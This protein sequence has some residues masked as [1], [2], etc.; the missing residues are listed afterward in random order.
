M[1]YTKHFNT[2]K[3]SQNQPIPG[4]NQVLNNAGGFVYET[5][6]WIRLDR[7][8]I[9][10]T[11]GGTYYA[12]EKKLTVENA[13]CILNLLKKDGQRVVN[14]VVQ[15]SKEGRASKNDPAIFVLAMAAKMGDDATRAVA[16]EAIP[17]VCRIG[18][19]IFQFAEAVKAFGGWGRGTRN[20]IARWY[21][22]MPID[23]LSYQVI[24]YQQRNGWSHRDLLRLSHAKTKDQDRNAIY[25]WVTKGLPKGKS[26][27]SLDGSIIQGF[28][29]VKVASSSIEVA[30]LIR[31]FNLPREV[32]PTEFLNYSSV[33]EA[34]LEKMP[35]MAMIRNLATM[36]RVGLLAPMNIATDVVLER[37]SDKELLRKARIHP[38]QV[39]AALKTYANGCGARG[40]NSWDPVQSIVDALDSAFYASF[41]YIKPSGKKTFLAVDCSASMKWGQICGVPGLTPMIGAAALAMVQARV[42]KKHFIAYFSSGSSRSEGIG[43]LKISPRM[44]LDSVVKTL[45]NVPWGG[46]D[47]SLPMLYAIKKKMEVD[48]FVILT[49]NETWAGNIH[50][51]QALIRYRNEFKRDVKLVS[52]GMTSTGFTIA[53]PGDPGMMDIVGF[54]TATPQL[55]ADFTS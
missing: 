15:I 24:K 53:D 42:E 38:V 52:V 9:L 11:E 50:P 19:H 33:W 14:R 22:D 31:E 10:G 6:E 36:T 26:L 23:K 49:D 3:T 12:S 35:Y 48:N 27:S 25:R 8:L 43:E 32:I 7:F 55:I 1:N 37:L 44:R 45:S 17:E 46:T 28:E 13:K 20:A 2:Q 47:C 16:R 51:S 54:D 41:G 40:T 18:T 5:D 4:K 30:K 34:L 21:N 29:K 39:L